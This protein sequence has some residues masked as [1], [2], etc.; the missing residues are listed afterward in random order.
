[1][2]ADRSRALFTLD[3]RRLARARRLD[4]HLTKLAREERSVVDP[5]G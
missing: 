5:T 3:R 4:H 2:P 1:M